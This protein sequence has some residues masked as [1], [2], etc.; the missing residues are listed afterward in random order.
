VV[1]V[2]DSSDLTVFTR[3]GTSV[4]IGSAN[5]GPWT[6][7]VVL[8][9]LGSSRIFRRENPVRPAESRARCF[10]GRHGYGMA[11]FIPIRGDIVL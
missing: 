11:L 1:S 10:Q 4:G 8:F 6:T 5:Q 3:P 9:G 7:M 2:G